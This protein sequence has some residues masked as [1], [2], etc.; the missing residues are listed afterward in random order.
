MR[1]G[2]LGCEPGS[3]GPPASLSFSLGGDMNQRP[4]Q[5][6]RSG[7]LA[8]LLAAVVLAVL[9]SVLPMFTG[10]G[11]SKTGKIL[12]NLEQIQ[13]MKQF[14]AKDHISTGPGE[15]SEQDLA[16]Y[17]P[18]SHASDQLVSPVVGERYIINAVGIPP[19][20]RLTHKLGN[21]PDGTI[22]RLHGNGPPA[23]EIVLPNRVAGRIAL[24]AP[25]PPDMRV[26]IR[27]LRSD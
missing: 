14:W 11:P 9:W 3:A 21:L 26:R 12:N 19:E 24:P 7:L 13:L 15:P 27:R 8:C 2:H 22:I 17:A 1:A 4:P 16:R 25:T 10:G 6:L 23:Y 5:Q 18:G 20:A